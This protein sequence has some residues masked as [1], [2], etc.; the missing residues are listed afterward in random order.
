MPGSCR[1]KSILEAQIPHQFHDS[2]VKMESLNMAASPTK[3]PLP[4][5]ICRLENHLMEVKHIG[6]EGRA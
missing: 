2:G 3:C 1:C 4:Q 5:A 6:Q